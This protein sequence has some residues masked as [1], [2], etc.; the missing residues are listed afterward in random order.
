MK[1]FRKTISR[2]LI[3]LVVVAVVVLAV[4]GI[5][6]SRL[7]R[8]GASDFSADLEGFENGVYSAAGSGFAA[9]T[10]VSCRLYS[11][12][13]TALST[14]SRSYPDPMLASSDGYALVWSEGGTGIT[15]LRA[16]GSTDLSFSGGVTAA[17]VNDRGTAVILAGEVGYKGSVTAVDGTGAALYRVYLGTG[18]GVDTDISPD[19]R[20]LAILALNAE[21]STVTLYALDSE[22]P[23]WETTLSGKT[24]FELEYLSDGRILVLCAE[25]ALFLGSDGRLLGEVS[26]D[27]EYLKAFDHGEG[28]AVLALG[29]Y[30]SGSAGRVLVLDSAGNTLGSLDSGGD[31]EGLDAAGKYF[32]LRG[33]DEVRIFDSSLKLLGRLE[34]T[35]GIQA[36]LMRPSG[37]AIIV[38]GGGA[39]VFEP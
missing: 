21:G 37:S 2:L 22:D 9:A 19:S 39:A 26:F 36:A 10:E 16:G 18:Y 28:F 8:S 35:A 3:A 38:S 6:G 15:L 1:D 17:D 31:I 11:L 13:G 34:G 14:V 33:S 27:G 7:S 5:L 20:R 12:W 24:C 23:L 25:S 32:A 4:A 29:P 30:R